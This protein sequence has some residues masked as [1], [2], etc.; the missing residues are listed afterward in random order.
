MLVNASLRVYP[1][2]NKEFEVVCDASGTAF[3]YVVQQRDERGCPQ[4]IMASGRSLR[5]S[6]ARYGISEKE[7][8]AL[9]T[10]LMD[11]AAWF[12]YKKVTVI[13]DHLSNTWLS[14][15]KNMT[16]RLGRWSLLL[17]Q[18]NLDIKYRPGRVLHVDALSRI[19][20][21]PPPPEDPN[22][23]VTND[24]MRLVAALQTCAKTSPKTQRAQSTQTVDLE[25]SHD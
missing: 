10:A 23:E 4:L 24:D 19:P 22:D 16:G 3:G 5:G 7:G 13:T 20:Y 12:R 6:E 9:V 11:N 21:P 14:N 15:I 8:L 18:F 25:P 17:S 1:D 2:L